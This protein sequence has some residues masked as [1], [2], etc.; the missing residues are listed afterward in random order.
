M[1][2]S[3]LIT[4]SLDVTKIPT[5]KLII[6]K[7][8]KYLNVSIWVNEEQD[9]FGNDVSVQVSQ[10]KEEREAKTDKVYLGNGRVYKSNAQTKGQPQEANAGED[11]PF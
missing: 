3:K 7:K 6:G 5:D 9:Q 4:A 11:L 8:G 2:N 1:S 10:S